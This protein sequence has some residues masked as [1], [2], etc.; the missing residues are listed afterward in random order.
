MERIE[1]A[2][3]PDGELPVRG[4]RRSVRVQRRLREL[5]RGMD[6]CG[7]CVVRQTAR[8]RPL[9]LADDRRNARRLVRERRAGA[10]LGASAQP[11]HGC[12]PPVGRYPGRTAQAHRDRDALQPGGCGPPV[13]P[14]GGILPRREPCDRPAGHRLDLRRSVELLGSTFTTRINGTVVDATTHTA[15]V[16][17]NIGFRADTAVEG[18]SIDTVSVVEL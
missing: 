12:V 10:A 1:R 15:H 3:L 16:R 2:R 18:A 14:S 6:R 7:R 11:A 4:A 17:G 8:V 9:P 13:R 5:C